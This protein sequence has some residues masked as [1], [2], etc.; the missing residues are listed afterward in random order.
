[1]VVSNPIRLT[2]FNR[3]IEVKALITVLK[4]FTL[5]LIYY[6][7]LTQITALVF[8]LVLIIVTIN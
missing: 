7:N 6:L 1:M 2:A 5:F 3:L 8:I 4:P